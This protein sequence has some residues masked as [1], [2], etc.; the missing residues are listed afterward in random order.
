MALTKISGDVIQTPV[1]VGVVTAST[2]NVGSAVTIHS[3]GFRIGSSDLHSSGLTVQNL[4]STGVVTATTFS[5]N[6]TGNINSTG[7]STFTTLRVGTAVTISGG[8]VT[9]TSFY[10][11][12]TN[13]TNTGSTLSAASGSQRVVL[14]GQ[15]SGTMTASAT[16][17]SLTFDAST[18][19]LSATKF[20]G[21]GSTL[22]GIA[23]TTNVRTN[24]L[25]VSGITT[26]AAGSTSAP[27]ITPT[28]DSNTGIFF[29]SPDTIAF[30]EGGVEALR[31]DSSAN[32]GIGT[33][34]PTTSNGAVGKNI[35][36]AG[37]NNVVLSFLSNNAG[38]GGILEFRK[39][40]RTGGERYAQIDGGTDANNNGV[41][42][43]YTSP[44]GSASANT[45]V[46]VTAYSGP[47]S[48]KIGL[49]GSNPDNV[50]GFG[51]SAYVSLDIG[52][53]PTE[54]VTGLRVTRSYTQHPGKYPNLYAI[55]GCLNGTGQS[56]VEKRDMGGVYG[57]TAVELSGGIV[58]VAS[59]GVYTNGIAVLADATQPNTDGYGYTNAFW[60]DIR[61]GAGATNGG[62]RGMYLNFV[63]NYANHEGIVFN[64]AYTGAN[65]ITIGRWVR[66]GTQVGSI[67]CT[68]SATTYGSGSDY[69]L[70]ENIV[71]L[72][73][74]IDRLKQLSV[75]RFNFISEPDKTVDGF[76][77]HE[78]QPF[79][80]EAVTGVKDEMQKVPVFDE[81]EQP[82]FN[83]DGTQVL[84][85]E[86]V[87]QNIDQS[88]I[89]P[90]LTA[91]LQEALEKIDDL[92]ARLDAAGL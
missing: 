18:G 44:S 75:Y 50:V 54:P 9:A 60:G 58:G 46:E 45:A 53:Q 26:V 84:K 32:I 65:T 27:S 43:V 29:P 38:Y 72:T 20:S 14:T 6:I 34:N 3:G 89:V 78:V 56:G 68:T 48:N 86:P 13:L 8:I 76:I 49:F 16:S 5:G 66:N 23:A 52:N 25:V 47:Y 41:L 92:Q 59:C 40:G 87:Y 74:A 81:N 24:S 19:T 79:V 71:P 12:G 91:A 88:K 67:T 82:I 30:A 2:I 63:S 4:N 61:K 55:Q 33:D 90:L 7:V 37:N 64:T 15:T 77:A 70:K 31:I 51:M 83:E 10:G 28:G 22:T 1:N 35:S 57:L 69:R 85:D 80:P 42:R 36:I 73:G 39:P 17:S 11:D 62:L 21:D